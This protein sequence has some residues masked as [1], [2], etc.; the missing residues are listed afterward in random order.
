MRGRKYLVTAVRRSNGEIVL[1]KQALSSMYTGKWRSMPLARG[2]IVLIEAM[3]FGIKSLLFSANVSLEEEGE[4][5]S[6]IWIW[7]ML[8][9]SMAVAVAIFFMGPLFLTRLFNIASPFLFN[10]VE[11][12]IR[13]TIFVIYLNLIG[14]MPDIKRVFSYHGAEHKAV[15]CYESGKKLSVENARKHTTY[16]PR[17][18]TSF[19]LIVI[20]IKEV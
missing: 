4:E 5:V 13:L 3:V 17:C 16:H 6:G 18:G 2:I 8:A 10:I 7:V 12:A 9:V 11:G 1:D 14:L 19:L 20:V 15:F